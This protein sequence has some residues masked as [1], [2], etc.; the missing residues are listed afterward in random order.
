MKFALM[1][2]INPNKIGI[3]QPYFFPYTGHF[4]LIA[5]TDQWVIFDETQFTPKSWMNR[6]RVLHPN[7]GWNWIVAPLANSSIHIKIKDAQVLNIEQARISTLGKLT[8]YRKKA[9]FYK[10]VIEIV[11]DCFALTANEKSLVQLNTRSLKNVCNYLE[12]PFN[13][14]ICSEL[15]IN[16]PSIMNPDDW[17]LVICESQGY[18]K[19]INPVGGRNIFDLQKYH[20]ASIEV[21]FLETQSLVYTPKGYQFEKDLSILDA[22]MWLPPIEIKKHIISTSRLID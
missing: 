5:Q 1:N 14:K 8:H 16:F 2:E 3:M 4:S 17:A 9:P 22:L 15:N 19:Y 13:Y 11:E 7:S 21:K 20:A 12:I 18:S 6:N 10:K